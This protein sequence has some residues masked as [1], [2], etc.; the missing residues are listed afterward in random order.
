VLAGT[1]ADWCY[2][3]SINTAGVIV[4]LSSTGVG[5]IWKNGQA[6]D[7]NTLISSSNSKL[8]EA[9][10]ITDQGWIL[11]YIYATSQ[12]TQYVLIPK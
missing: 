9:K 5:T 10:L 1:S 8:G 2:A 12:S 3:N 11:G 4:G 7:L 6:Q